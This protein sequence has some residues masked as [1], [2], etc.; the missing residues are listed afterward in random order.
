MWLSDQNQYGKLAHNFI[1][2]EM[3]VISLNQQWDMILLPL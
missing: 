3:M 2:G 1:T